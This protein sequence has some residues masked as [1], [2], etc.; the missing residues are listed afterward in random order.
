[1]EL[2]APHALAGRGRGL[3]AL[4]GRVVAVDE[5]GLPA[6]RERVAERERVLVVLAVAAAVASEAAPQTTGGDD[7]PR[8]VHPPRLDAPRRREREHG[9]VVPAVP[10]RHAVRLQPGGHADDLVA[11][12][13]AEDGLVPLLDRPPQHARGVHA[14][15][16]VAGAVAQ[17][18]PVV[19]VADGVEVVVPGQDG[20][21]CASA[22]ERSEDIRL[23]AKVEHGDADVAERI[24]GVRFL[25]RGLCNEVLASWVPVFVWIWRGR[26]DIRTDC[27]P[28]EGGPLV[29]EDASDGTRIHIGDTGNVISETPVV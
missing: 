8:H 27:E 28:A 18:Q 5:E 14:V 7:L 20:T 4:D 23:C 17:E 3:D 22:D 13:D 9:L 6:G 25:D 29:T 19:L 15:R 24:E 2:H 12:A 10:E 1:M 11:H 21:R 16:G 26:V